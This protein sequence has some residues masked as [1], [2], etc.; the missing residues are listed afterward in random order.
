V[1]P[2][3]GRP[4]GTAKDRALLL[5]GVRWRSREELRRRLSAAG[6]EVEDVER[7]LTDL[8]RVGLIDD[9]RF[10][11]EVVA[12]QAGRRLASDRA[13]RHA[14]R[15]KGVAPDAVDATLATAGDESDRA[16]ELARRQAVRLA[17]LPLEAASSRILGL[18]LRRGYA[19]P[20]AREATARAL[21]A[22]TSEDGPH[23][24]EFP[25]FHDG[26]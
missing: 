6:F 19:G 21:T 17:H 9:E 24:V 5:L 25:P 3:D 23:D 8:E 18:L 15:G 1:G 4:R 20:I 7:A 2:A 10:A 14:L 26:P 11:R 22:R 13:I 12:Q 16:A